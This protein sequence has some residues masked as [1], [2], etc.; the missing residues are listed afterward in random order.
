MNSSIKVNLI[1][2]Q[3]LL[4]E[5]KQPLRLSSKKWWLGTFNL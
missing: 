1:D 2:R 3:Q 4:F 5:K